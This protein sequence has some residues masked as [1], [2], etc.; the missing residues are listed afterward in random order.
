M[1]SRL[2]AAMERIT[3]RAVGFN[4]WFD[5]ETQGPSLEVMREYVN[6]ARFEQMGTLQSIG[7]KVTAES[8]GRL[9]Q[10]NVDPVFRQDSVLLATVNYHFQEPENATLVLDGYRGMTAEAPELLKRVFN[11]E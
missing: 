1:M 4:F 2:I 5:G 10:L 9:V 7:L 3:V 6:G 8:N 11:A